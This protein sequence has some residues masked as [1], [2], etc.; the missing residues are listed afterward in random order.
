LY[1]YK[2]SQKH[3]ILVFLVILLKNEQPAVESSLNL[4]QEQCLK[5]LLTTSTPSSIH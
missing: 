2:L 1:Y 4:Q 3:T 5:K